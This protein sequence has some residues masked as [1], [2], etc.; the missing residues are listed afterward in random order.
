M[1]NTDFSC[2]IVSTDSTGSR[3]GGQVN[4]LTVLRRTL[5]VYKGALKY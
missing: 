5:L 3:G 1:K 4:T 2:I